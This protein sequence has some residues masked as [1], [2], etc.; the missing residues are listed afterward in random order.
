MPS[1]PRASR[2][3]PETQPQQPPAA[4]GG[5]RRKHWAAAAA[6]A[7]ALVAGAWYWPADVTA[8]AAVPARAQAGSAFLQTPPIPNS[9]QQSQAAREVRLQELTSQLEMADQTL[10]SYREGTKYPNSS[11]P[12]AEHP[13]QVYPNHPVEESHAMRKQGGGQDATVQVQTSQSRVYMAAGESAAFSIKAVDNEGKPLPVFITRAVARG[14][15]FQATREAPQ[16]ALSFTDDGSNGDVKANDGTFSSVLAP[17]QTEFAQ[18]NGTIRTEVRYNVGDRSGIVVFDVIY[19]PENP[20]TWTGQIR[21]AIEDGSLSFYL[22][23][24]VRM[25]GR[26]IVN[27]RVDDA[28]GKPFALVNFNDLLPQGRSEIRLTVF[29]KLLRDQAP[30]MPLRLRDVDAYLL[31]E[32]VDPDR[33]LMPRLEGTAHVSKTYALK[34]FSEA[35]WQSE[36]RSRYLAEFGKDLDIARKALVEFNPEQA[37]QPFPQ[38]ECSRKVAAAGKGG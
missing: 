33:A 30:A 19:S 2:R 1:K 15:T 16:V 18:F 10:C 17:A 11:R 38:S 25:P 28:N 27:G 22:K 13:D 36:E 37:K 32:N 21:E 20:A 7:L 29:G 14:L 9:P 35:E 23:A 34:N 6:A 3:K 26:Y 8:T 4:G 5:W 31:K 12:I 24:D